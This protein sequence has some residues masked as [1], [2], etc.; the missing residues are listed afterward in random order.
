MEIMESNTESVSNK[1][2]K[3]FNE[4]CKQG[5]FEDIVK[6]HIAF[7]C[8]LEIITEEVD[9]ELT[10]AY[11]KYMKSNW[12]FEELINDLCTNND[13]IQEAIC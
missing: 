5:H 7:E 8:G 2:L 13:I 11:D 1:L 4:L 10:E 3:E 12:T 6:A 9:K